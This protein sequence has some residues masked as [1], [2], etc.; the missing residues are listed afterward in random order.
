MSFV[1]GVL[2]AVFIPYTMKLQ[3][4][5]VSI[6]L[7]RRDKNDTFW[8]KLGMALMVVHQK[9]FIGKLSD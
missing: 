4:D 2:K 8:H 6:L 5:N 3:T 7:Y 9:A 1:Q